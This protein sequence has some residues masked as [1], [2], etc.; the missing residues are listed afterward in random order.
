M[1]KLFLLRTSIIEISDL[2]GRRRVILDQY[3]RFTI[4]EYEN[5]ISNMIEL[6]DTKYVSNKGPLALKAKIELT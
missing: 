1:T 2:I 3:M 4:E 6:L 5:T